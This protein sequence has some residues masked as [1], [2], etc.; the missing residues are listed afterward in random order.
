MTSP[1]SACCFIKDT[2]KGAFCIF[3]SLASLLPFCDEMLV[4]DLG[5]TDGTLETLYEISK[6]NH[7][8]R[9][10][11]DRFPLIDASVFAILAN[12][13]VSQC[14]HEN[15]LYFQADEIW[16]QDLLTRMGNEFEQGNF[17]L[18]F[19]RIQYQDNFHLVK[20]FPHLVHRVGKKGKFNFVGDGMT[21]DRTWDAHICS[22][23]DGGWFQRWGA[24]HQEGIKP[25]VNDMIMDVSLIGGFLEN[26]VER[27]MLHAPFWRESSINGK[28]VVEWVAEARQ[29]PNWTKTESPYNLPHIMRY[30]VGKLKYQLRDELFQALK[31]NDT[32][33]MVWGS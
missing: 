11:L 8:I 20:W 32:R 18:S 1:V 17:D 21:T 3:E 28:P 27:K 22:E 30:H 2:F 5:S 7:K 6:A 12:D 9:L 23:Y 19:W 24:L 29:N 13:L 25:Y 31:D 4:M 26:I 16:H 14:K 15:V 10:I 33:G